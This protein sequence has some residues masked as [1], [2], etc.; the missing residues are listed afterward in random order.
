[1]TGESRDTAVTSR[2]TDGATGTDAAAATARADEADST[3]DF[4]AA[5][6]A[7]VARRID[8]VERRW[9][10]RKDRELNRARRRWESEAGQSID[11][12]L[13][14]WIAEAD[15]QAVGQ[16]L[17]TGLT[18]GLAPNQADTRRPESSDETAGQPASDEPASGAETQ[19]DDQDDAEPVEAAP[20]PVDLER[21]AEAQ[22]RLAER[23]RQDPSPDLFP[24]RGA[25][26]DAF[27]QIEAG[28][29]RGEVDLE[30]YE[31]A[32]R[33]RGLT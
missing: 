21:E 26:A 31:T 24:S 9:Q 17:K 13:L 27:Q 33:R 23:R 12:E 6:E 7:E 18:E 14:A 30:T 29:A 10:S 19:H 8:A 2:S 28:F 16:W 3:D 22:D 20:P 15:P 25:P 1:M 32:R 5:L 11:P 4:Q